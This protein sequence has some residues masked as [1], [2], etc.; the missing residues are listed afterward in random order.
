MKQ[1]FA[2]SDELAAQIRQGAKVDVYAAAN[3]KLPDAAP[4]DGLLEHAGGVRHQR[5]RA[6]RAEGLARST[7][8]TTWPSRERSW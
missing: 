5:V 1:S 6:G 3:T 4:R 7:R 8:S 2:G